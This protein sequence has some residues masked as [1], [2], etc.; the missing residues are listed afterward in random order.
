M[1]SII[2]ESRIIREVLLKRIKELDLTWLDIERDAQ[3]NG[4]KVANS[5]LSKYFSAS[6]SNNL[7]E[8]A[9]VWLCTRYG[10]PIS[11]FVGIASVKADGKVAVKFAP[12]NETTC[13]NNLKAKFPEYSKQKKTKKNKS[14]R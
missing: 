6:K 10:I 2:K 7:S 12:Y 4:F 3:L 14:S 9:I 8:E 11:V 13:L 1:K 5:S